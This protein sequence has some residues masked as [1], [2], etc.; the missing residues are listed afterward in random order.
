MTR[1]EAMPQ[2]LTLEP[3]ISG[4]SGDNLLSHPARASMGQYLASRGELVFEGELLE[5]PLRWQPAGTRH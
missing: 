3:A 5:L 2:T 4:K 1:I